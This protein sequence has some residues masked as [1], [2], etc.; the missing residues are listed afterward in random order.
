MPYCSKLANKRIDKI[1][2]IVDL[3]GCEI[4]PLIFSEEIRR[5]L[6]TSSKIGQD[7]YPETMGQLWIV[8][9]PFMFSVLWSIL[10]LWLDEKTKKKIKIYGSGFKKDLLKVV[11][12]DNLPDFLGGNITDHPKNRLPWS[13]Y[14]DYCMKEKTFEPLTNVNMDDP[15]EVAKLNPM[16]AQKI[17]LI[18]KEKS[19][20]KIDLFEDLENDYFDEDACCSV[21]SLRIAQEGSMFTNSKKNSYDID[22]PS[23]KTNLNSTCFS[24]FEKMSYQI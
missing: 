6:Q 16:D 22:T 9:A 4:S 7:N 8:N 14:V 21:Q 2:T 23:N 12:S 17:E 11:D 20:V 15:M 1:I 24:S 3:D 10:K 5:Y 19:R 18:K 13:D